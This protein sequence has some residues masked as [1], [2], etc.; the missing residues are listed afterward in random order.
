MKFYFLFSK[1]KIELLINKFNLIYII[2]KIKVIYY[3]YNS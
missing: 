1:K 3:F 2:V